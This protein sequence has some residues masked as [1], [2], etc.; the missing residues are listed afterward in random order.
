MKTPIWTYAVG[1][2]VL[3]L[4]VVA[5]NSLTNGFTCLFNCESS[6]GISGR[7]SNL[8]DSVFGYDVESAAEEKQQTNNPKDTDRE[9]ESKSVAVSLRDGLRGIL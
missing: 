2:L 5:F 1:A 4:L 9:V 8:W 6:D 7:L 3:A